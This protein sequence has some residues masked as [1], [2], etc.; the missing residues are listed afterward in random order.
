[1]NRERLTPTRIAA[2][3]C[4]EGKQQGFIWDTEVPRLAVRA[5]GS[6]KSFIFEA[7]LAGRTVRVTIGAVDVWAVGDARIEARRLQT[8]VDKGIDPRDERREKDEA[9]E[10]RKSAAEAEKREQERQGHYT[11]RK[12]C[13]A[14]VDFLDA[15]GKGRS[16]RDTASVFKCHLYQGHAALCDTPARDVTAR[17]LATVVRKAMEDGKERTAGKLRSFLLAAYRAA[18]RAPFDPKL[19]AALIPFDVIANPVEPLATIPVRAGNRVLSDAELKVF[20]EAL[21]DSPM[22]RLLKVALLAG[23]QRIQQ[24]LRAR[25]GDFDSKTGALRLFD[26]KGKRATPREHV[27]PLAPR[28]AGIV[29]DLS[30]LARK[31]KSE[32]KTDLLFSSFGTRPIAPETISNRVTDIAKDLKGDPFQARDLRRTAETMLASMGISRDVRAQLLSHGISGVQAT[33]YDRHSYMDEKRA[34]LVAWEKRIA[35]IEAGE[36][37]PENVR[38][39][40]R[41]RGAAA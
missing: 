27:L 3:A 7:K 18:V 30:D 29:A 33:H 14:Y 12:L 4:P 10:A 41:K 32:G 39:L 25:A 23:G 13:E 36:K 8:L 21:K 1:M 28:A 19:P 11:L 40:P 26:P 2:F 9:R 38:R 35:A 24:L 15:Q 17:Q 5:S 20:I 34:A 16:A 6:A 37:A 22:D 31:R